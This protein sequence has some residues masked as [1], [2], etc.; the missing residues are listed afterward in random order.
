[1]HSPKTHRNLFATRTGVCESGRGP[2]PTNQPSSHAGSNQ[3]DA[4]TISLAEDA[5]ASADHF[6][7]MLALDE[8]MTRLEAVDSR[9]SKVVEMRF[10]AGMNNQEI[11]EV[12]KVT[13]NTVIRDWNFAEAWLRR[14]LGV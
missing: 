10:F 5:S 1:M 4:K 8:A 6:L 2:T 3:A 9:K 7:D 11:A 13:A 14:E 12:L